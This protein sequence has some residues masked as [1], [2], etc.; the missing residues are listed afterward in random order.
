MKDL[1]TNVLSVISPRPAES[2]K[3]NYG[4]VL[5]IGGNEN[6]GGA[7]IMSTSAAVHAG[8]GLVTCATAPAN[9]TALHSTVPEAMFVD[10]TDNE[11]VNNVLKSTTAIVLGPGL[12][13][14]ETSKKIIA[15]VFANVSEEQYLIIDGSAITL[16]AQE[17]DLQANLPQA[18]IIF[19]P[20]EMEW[21]RLSGIKI[22]QQTETANRVQQEKLGATV[23]LKKHHTEIYAP[24][25]ETFRLPLGGPYM[26]TGG[27]GDTLTGIIAAFMGQFAKTNPQKA[28]QAAVYTHSA[29]AD[30]LS[31]NAYVVLPTDII[32][33]LQKFMQEHS[34][35]NYRTK[36]GFN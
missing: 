14:D 12:G 17:K 13:T 24:N 8:A 10:Y 33:H 5:T 20:H 18:H 35:E 2:Y 22:A 34:H 1:D 3:G 30:Q 11:A 26:S 21:Q 28:L 29:I 32:G 16:L 19:T 25:A 27:M 36:I 9:L 6:F 4:R 15:N 31:E 7:I 23:I